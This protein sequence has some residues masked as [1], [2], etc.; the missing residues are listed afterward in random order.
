MEVL[1]PI[2][3]GICIRNWA[4]HIRTRTTGVCKGWERSKCARGAGPKGG[5][6]VP[7]HRPRFLHQLVGRGRVLPLPLLREVQVLDRVGVLNLWAV[8][9]HHP[10]RFL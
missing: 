8:G 6:T 9:L 3:I 4:P 2:N 10:R 7:V 1:M 5:E